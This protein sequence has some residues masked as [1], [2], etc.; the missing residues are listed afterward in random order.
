MKRYDSD[1]ADLFLHSFANIYQTKVI[2][3]HAGT[4]TRYII[5]DSYNQTIHLC[6]NEDHYDLLVANKS[7]KLQLQIPPDPDS[8]DV[9]DEISEIC[10]IIDT[11]W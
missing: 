3:S 5:G 8:P 2:V 6:K 9:G 4:D 11:E 7:K 10:N 1:T